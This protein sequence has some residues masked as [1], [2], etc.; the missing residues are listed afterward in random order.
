[1]RKLIP[2]TVHEILIVTATAALVAAVVTPRALVP[3]ARVT[4]ASSAAGAH[5]SIPARGSVEGVIFYT[6]GATL[7]LDTT[8]APPA[9]PPLAGCGGSSTAHGK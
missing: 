5:P 3:R 6:T 1:M 8:T 4:P 2:L 9:S 7:T